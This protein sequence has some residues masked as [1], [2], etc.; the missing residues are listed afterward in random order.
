MRNHKNSNLLIRPNVFIEIKARSGDQVSWIRGKNKVVDA[1]L[2]LMRDLLGGT[3]SRPSHL[4]VGTGSTAPAAADSSIETEVFRELI[5]RRIDSP[6]SIRY[7]LYLGTGDANGFT[8]AEAGLLQTGAQN[9]SAGDPALLVA[10][11]TYTSFAKTSSI[12]VTYNW[13]FNLAAS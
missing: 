1:G 5:T 11:V 3:G 10:R 9:A 7:Q 13:D 8:L 4:G 2:N 12:E 6:Q